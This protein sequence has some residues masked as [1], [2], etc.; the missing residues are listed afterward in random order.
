MPVPPFFAVC[1][2]SLVFVRAHPPS[3]SSSVVRAES[4]IIHPLGARW[5]LPPAPSRI[6]TWLE[7]DLRRS[8]MGA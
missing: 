2:F 6:C 3:S 1:L 5:A 4:S 8:A 7:R